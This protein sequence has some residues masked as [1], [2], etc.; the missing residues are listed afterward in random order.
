MLPDEPVAIAAMGSVLKAPA[1]ATHG[2]T[3]T[4]MIIIRTGS[5]RVA[6]IEN[7][8]RSAY[9]FDQR[10]ELFGSDGS[11][12]M[13]NR[14]PT[15]VE[16][17]DASG[18]RRRGPLVDGFIDRYAQAYTAEFEHFVSAALDGTPVDVGF[19]DGRRALI[20]ADAVLESLRTDAFVALDFGHA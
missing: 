17:W 2:D 16:R 13:T 7:H 3:D 11:L 18:T 19:E 12:E 20:M 10:L 5:G 1:Y 6:H 8:R 4:L 15:S 14:R 9:G